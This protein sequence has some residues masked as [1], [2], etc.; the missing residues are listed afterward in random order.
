MPH[1]VNIVLLPSSAPSFQFYVRFPRSEVQPFSHYGSE[2]MTY[3]VRKE[4]KNSLDYIIRKPLS[5]G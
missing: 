2:K 3:G 1:N 4:T 5:R